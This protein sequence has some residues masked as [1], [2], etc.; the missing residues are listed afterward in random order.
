MN[1]KN[2]Y[3]VLYAEATDGVRTFKASK[4]GTFSDA[5]VI[6]ELEIGKY[7]LIYEKEG[8]IY[9]SE[10]GVPSDDDDCVDAF[11]KLFAVV[12]NTKADTAEDTTAED[13]ADEENMEETD[14]VKNVTG[15][16]V[17]EEELPE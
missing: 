14:Q 8:K 5:E 15:E 3:K 13:T 7:K 4:T 1:L 6:A 11:D 9:C 17:T 16:S 2:D 12:D 10:A